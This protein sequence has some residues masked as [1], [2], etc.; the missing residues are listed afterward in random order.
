MWAISTSPLRKA[1]SRKGLGS[2][3]GSQ[4]C[5]T[6]RVPVRLLRGALGSA[7]PPGNR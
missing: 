6:R 1:L 7:G 3:L 4:P 2:R 5:E